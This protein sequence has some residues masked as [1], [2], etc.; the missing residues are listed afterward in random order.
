[1]GNPEVEYYLRNPEVKY[2]FEEP[3]NEI[4]KVPMGSFE[5]THH[6]EYYKATL[7]LLFGIAKGA[8][9]YCNTYRYRVYIHDGVFTRDTNIFIRKYSNGILRASITRK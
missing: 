8:R 7:G 5:S 6:Y 3:G 2:Y 9:M 4:F 1:M